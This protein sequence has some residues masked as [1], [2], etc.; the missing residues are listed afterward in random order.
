MTTW[1]MPIMTNH[2]TTSTPGGGNLS[3]HPVWRR[4][5]LISSTVFV[6][7]CRRNTV[8]RILPGSSSVGGNVFSAAPYAAAT[9]P[10]IAAVGIVPSI[11]A[12]SRRVCRIAGHSPSVVEV[13]HSGMRCEGNRS[14][15]FMTHLHFIRPGLRERSRGAPD[16]RRIAEIF[17]TGLAYLC[18]QGL[19]LPDRSGRR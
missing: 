10:S 5:S 9:D 14:T 16:R 4:W 13:Q 17:G 18:P 11:T 3:Y 19:H 6:W 8:S 15:S 7:S 12:R 2:A 1:P